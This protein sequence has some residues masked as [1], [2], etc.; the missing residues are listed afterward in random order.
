MSREPSSQESDYLSNA[1]GRK[2]IFAVWVGVFLSM[3]IAGL[4]LG[5]LTPEKPWYDTLYDKP[6]KIAENEFRLRVLRLHEQAQLGLDSPPLP[7]HLKGYLRL[8]ALQQ[9]DLKGV[10]DEQLLATLSMEARQR[11]AGE[12]FQLLR[13]ARV[14]HPHLY[15]MWLRYLVLL[16]SE[17]LSVLFPA[18]TYQPES[19]VDTPLASSVL[20]LEEGEWRVWHDSSGIQDEIIRRVNVLRPYDRDSLI[21]DPATPQTAFDP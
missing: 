20:V 16:E 19:P 10:S 13:N 18:C 8:Y 9:S 12:D 14:T 21:R 3:V 2:R 4:F 1:A 6:V 7:K 17:T 15:K 11:L 5:K